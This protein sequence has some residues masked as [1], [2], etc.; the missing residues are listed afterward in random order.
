VQEIKQEDIMTKD[1][2]IKNLT[3]DR[4][5]WRECYQSAKESNTSIRGWMK[6]N[7]PDVWR[8]YEQSILLNCMYGG[9]IK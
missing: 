1:T 8:R 2:T 9:E 4:D 3:A 6:E 7:A 5:Y